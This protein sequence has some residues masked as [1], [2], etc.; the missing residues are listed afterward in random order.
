MAFISLKPLLSGQA[1]IDLIWL[2]LG[3]VA[4]A[5]LAARAHPGAVVL[6]LQHGLWERNSLEAAVGIACQHVPVIARCAGNTPH[7]IFQ[8]L[9]SGASS[10]L[11]P[12]IESAEEAR[13]AVQASR[14]PPDGVRS[15]GGLRPLLDGVDAMLQTGAQ[16]AVGL[17]IETVKGVQNVES[18]MA[19]PGIDYIFIGTGDLALSLGTG[20]QSVLQRHC[21]QVLH[22][23]RA[24]GLPCGQY[25]GTAEAARQSFDAGYRIAVCASDVG[26]AKSGFAQ[27]GQFGRKK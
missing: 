17:M 21:Q 10:V 14:Y 18:I 27:A 4:L 19:V 11:V 24:R 7:Q 9:D 2:S 25:T 1:P 23:A 22:G 5:E 3:S 8:A 6:D 20:D 13:Q 16:V 12:L 15:A 26:A